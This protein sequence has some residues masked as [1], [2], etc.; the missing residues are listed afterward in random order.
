[1]IDILI[2][3]ERQLNYCIIMKFNIHFKFWALTAWFFLNASCENSD[4]KNEG[5]V[6]IRLEEKGIKIENIKA[7]VATRMLQE[8]PNITVL[9]IRTPEE[10]TTGH[11]SKAINID[12]KASNFESELKKLDRNQSILMHCRSGRRSGL[13]LET[14]RKLG[15]QHIVHIDDGILGW[16]EELVK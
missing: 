16:R 3:L 2:G 1:M 9:D 6:P 14:F 4:V 11:I 5:E 7:I 8:N 15:F 13:A 10:F 12:Y